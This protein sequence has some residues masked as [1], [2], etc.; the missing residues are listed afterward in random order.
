MAPGKIKLRVLVI[1]DEM[2][3]AMLLED[4]LL[5]IDAFD[6]DLFANFAEGLEAARNGTYAFA[7]LDVNLNGVRSYPIAD[8]LIQRKIPF[9]FSTGYGTAGLEAAY[10]DQTV[11]QKPFQVGELRKAIAKLLFAK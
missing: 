9:V 3:I 10:A 11:L 2:F 1:E 5:D 7:I 8:T 6:V 4:I